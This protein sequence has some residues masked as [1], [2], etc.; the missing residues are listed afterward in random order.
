MYVCSFTLVFYRSEIEKKSFEK[1][2]VNLR[3]T[4]HGLFGRQKGTSKVRRLE[5]PY[6]FRDDKATTMKSKTRKTS[7]SH[8]LAVDI[9]DL[10]EDS[11]VIDN[12]CKTSVSHT[13][14]VDIID[15]EEDLDDIVNKCLPGSLVQFEMKFARVEYMELDETELEV[16]YYIFVDGLLSNEVLVQNAH[17]F[18]D[19]GSMWSLLPGKWVD[20]FKLVLELGWTPQKVIDEYKDSFLLTADKCKKVYLPMNDANAHWYL[21]VILM[22]KKEVHMVDS[23]PNVTRHDIRLNAVGNMVKFMGELFNILYAKG[24]S[25]KQCRKWLTLRLKFHH[26]FL[27][28]VTLTKQSSSNETCI[29]TC[30]GISQSH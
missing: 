13:P 1:D 5:D 6:T 14:A 12:K 30:N 2:G 24:E 21:A 29:T 26:L 16:A 18:C 28:S 8:T 22:D 20:N 23:L 9:I 4:R 17:C 10:E 11:D 7:V 25:S 19:R 27:N 15:L 3:K